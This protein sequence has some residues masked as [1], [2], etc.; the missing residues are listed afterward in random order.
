MKGLYVF[1]I[2]EEQVLKIIIGLGNPGTRYEHTRHNVGF[3]VVDALSDKWGIPIKR[4]R[5]QAKIGEGFFCREK[6]LLIKPQTYMNRSGD[7]VKPILEYY[8][9]D[10]GDLLVV[11]DD[12]ALEPAQIRLKGKGSSGG[13]KGVQSII[14]RTGTLEFA[15]L[16]MG[17]GSTPPMINTPDYVLSVLNCH[18]VAQYQQAVEDSALAIEVWMQWGIEKAMN[19]FNSKKE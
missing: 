19:Q 3:W 13:H 8:G 18:E 11:F 14:E 4:N 15:R 16:R 5:F 12:L 17:I 6:V 9:A 10:L 7:V 1:L 2:L